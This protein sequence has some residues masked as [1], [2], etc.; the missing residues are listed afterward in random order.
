MNPSNANK[1]LVITTGKFTRGAIKFA[2]EN[3]LVELWDRNKL[4]EQV[5]AY[6][7]G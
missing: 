6:L 4:E 5:K 7:E 2:D 1:A 3:P